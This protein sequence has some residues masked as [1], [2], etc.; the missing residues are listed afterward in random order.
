MKTHHD[1]ILEVADYFGV[2]PREVLGG[3]RQ[4]ARI[5]LLRHL[6]MWLMR[7]HIA[8]ISLSEIAKRMGLRDHS[9]ICNG[10]ART[11]AKIAADPGFAAQVLVIESHLF[12]STAKAGAA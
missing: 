8:D 7:K 3:G 2:D 1:I 9:T 6:C 11:D 4:M 5:V 10:I 12:D